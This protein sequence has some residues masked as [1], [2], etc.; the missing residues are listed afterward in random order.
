G[1]QSLGAARC[2]A[3][4][5]GRAL[6]P[7]DRSR[8]AART[9]SGAGVAARRCMRTVNRVGIVAFVVVA[10]VLILGGS[11]VASYN[12]LVRLEPAVQAQ[13][14]EVEN[15]YQRRAD[16]IPNLVATVKGAADFER[17]TVTAVT[18]AR[19]HVGQMTVPKDVTTNPEEFK[20]FQDAQDQLGGAL[21]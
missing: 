21:S 2:E 3:R 9:L 12:R 5:A 14:A 8:S 7:R 10:I 4:R 19:S 15:T 11:C 20:K 16:L 18:E 13:W 17:S 6:A 1:P